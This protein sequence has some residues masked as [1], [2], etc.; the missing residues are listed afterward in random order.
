MRPGE[1]P[2]EVSVAHGTR[3]RRYADRQTLSPY[4]SPGETEAERPRRLLRVMTS[5]GLGREPTPHPPPHAMREAYHMLTRC[6]EGSRITSR[7]V[8]EPREEPRAPRMQNKNQTKTGT[9]KTKLWLRSISHR[10]DSHRSYW[11]ARTGDR[12]QGV[13]R[14]GRASLGWVSGGWLSRSGGSSQLY[15]LSVESGRASLVPA[16]FQ[17]IKHKTKLAGGV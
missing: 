14:P 2:A 15:S 8:F 10:K 11:R 6:R 17:S 4:L 7:L 12:R 13:P 1:T 16:F 3:A 9:G 5:A